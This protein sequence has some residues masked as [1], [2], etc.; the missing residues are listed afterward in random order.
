MMKIRNDITSID[1]PFT[2]Y[3]RWNSH[4]PWEHAS[5]RP[6]ETAVYRERCDADCQDSVYFQAQFDSLGI[7]PMEA[8]RYYLRCYI[9]TTGAASD[10]PLYHILIGN[11]SYNPTMKEEPGSPP[12]GGMYRA[13]DGPVDSFVHPDARTMPSAEEKKAIDAKREEIRR[14]FKKYHEEEAQQK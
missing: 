6:G 13:D 11:G 4:S 14:L 10:A 3:H 8:G 9:S 2:F 1:Q 5:L 7:E 12:T